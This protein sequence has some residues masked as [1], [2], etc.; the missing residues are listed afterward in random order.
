ML[1][2]NA[3]C[4]IL[5]IIICFALPVLCKYLHKCGKTYLQEK[6]K[7][8]PHLYHYYLKDHFGNNRIVY[9]YNTD[10]TVTADQEK[11]YGKSRLLL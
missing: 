8:N 5:Y 1:Y 7:K 6:V 2:Y 3:L 9:H 4:D 11:G 10:N